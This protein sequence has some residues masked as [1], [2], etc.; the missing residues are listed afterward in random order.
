MSLATGSG[1]GRDHDE[2]S[3]ALEWL[4]AGMMVLW[5]VGL[6][7][8]WDSFGGP[9]YRHLAALAAQPVWGAFSLAIGLIRIAALYYNGGWHRTPL[10]R[11][12]G[13]LLGTVWW[14][15]LLW[16]IWLSAREAGLPAATFWYPGLIAAELYACDRTGRDVARYRSLGGVR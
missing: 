12:L 5:G 15:V 6:M 2:Q 13:A 9:T 4:L 3:R 7:M 14:A 1:C 8:P 10:L 11:L 16:L